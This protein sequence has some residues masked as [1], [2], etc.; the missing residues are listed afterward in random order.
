MQKQPVLKGIDKSDVKDFSILHLNINWLLNK[1]F[2]IDSILNLKLYDIIFLNETKLFD[3]PFSFYKN[4]YYSIIRC[5]R[6][7]DAG[8]LVIFFKNSLRLNLVA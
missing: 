6:A 8:G 1:L 2:E 5:D 4:P 7:K 3:E